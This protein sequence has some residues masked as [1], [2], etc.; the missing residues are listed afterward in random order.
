VGP[1]G[2]ASAKIQIFNLVEE[3]WVVN[4]LPTFSTLP[5]GKFMILKLF[6]VF[7]VDGFDAERR[8]C[9][10]SKSH[11]SRLNDSPG[12]EPDGAFAFEPF[13]KP[14]FIVVDVRRKQSQTK[15]KV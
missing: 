5:I 11:E 12:T 15:P 1:S 3:E 9:G 8:M 13:K 7:D 6:S 14:R 2:T 4:N 10:F